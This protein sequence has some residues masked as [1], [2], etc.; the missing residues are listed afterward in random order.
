M[1][2]LIKVLSLVLKIFA[3]PMTNYFK[4][5]LRNTDLS[6]HYARTGVIYIGQAANVFYT[7]S[8]R[9]LMNTSSRSAYVKPLTEEAALDSGIET[10]G[11]VLLYGT[12]CTWGTWELYKHTVE[13]K[14]KET[15]QEAVLTDIQTS[16]SDLDF[17]CELISEELRSLQ[18]L[19]DEIYKSSVSAPFA[20]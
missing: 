9:V 10:L 19:L 17:K 18:G 1:I 8:Q 5:R 7:K 6:N 2:P 13:S 11:E 4:V 12:L 14:A 16:L 20:Y 15:S 3:K